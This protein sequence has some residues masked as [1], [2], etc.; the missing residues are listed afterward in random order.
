MKE[1]GEEIITLRE[2]VGGGCDSLGREG[3]EEGRSEGRAALLALATSLRYRGGCDLIFTSGPIAP[4]L[5]PWL[6]P[7]MATGSLRMSLWF[8]AV[9]SDAHTPSQVHRVEP[10]E[11]VQQDQRPLEKELLLNNL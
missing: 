6:Q 5:G 11:F 9:R 4:L 1:M 10:R 7:P 8:K 3:E 2:G